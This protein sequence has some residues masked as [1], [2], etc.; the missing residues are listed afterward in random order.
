VRRGAVLVL[1]LL[2]IACLFVVS[3]GFLS[4]T[5]SEASISKMVELSAQ[6]RELALAGLEGVRVRLLNDSKFPPPVLQNNQDF[7]SFVEEVPNAD[8][9]D[10][11]GRYQVHIDRRW[12]A[13][14]YSVLRVIC[15]GE[16]G[17]ES[18]P[19][20]HKLTCEFLMSEGKRGDLV[21]LLDEGE[22]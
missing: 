19:I 11:L 13:S 20:R 16:A 5:K 22:L 18:N 10:M 2:L 12:M 21:H 4:R 17:T 3:V 15:I 7:F 6:A 8:E 14:P 9:T 1:V